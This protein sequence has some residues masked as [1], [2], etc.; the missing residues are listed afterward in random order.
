MLVTVGLEN[1][2]LAMTKID[3]KY[4]YCSAGTS[5]KVTGTS[6]VS[7][8][9]SSTAAAVQYS[10]LMYSTARDLPLLKPDPSTQTWWKLKFPDHFL[11]RVKDNNPSVQFNNLSINKTSSD[12]LG[13]EVANVL[14]RYISR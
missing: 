7:G 5:Q 1:K 4:L 3:C 10:G 11:Y 9:Q 14:K 8:L 6:C 12:A 13:V 2:M